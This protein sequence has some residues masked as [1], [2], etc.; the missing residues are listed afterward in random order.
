M[1]RYLAQGIPD[2]LPPRYTT[3]PAVDH[4]PARKQVLTPAEKQLALRNALRYFP[5]AWHRELA[6]EFFRLL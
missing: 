1:R 5:A 6:A 4:V 2:E 3:N